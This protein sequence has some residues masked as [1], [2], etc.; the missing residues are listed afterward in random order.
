MNLRTSGYKLEEI[1]SMKEYG[2]GAPPLGVVDT[3][4]DLPVCLAV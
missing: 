1:S 3:N 2:M 4:P